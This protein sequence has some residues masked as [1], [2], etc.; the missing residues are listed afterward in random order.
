MVNSLMS[1]PDL[2]N[3]VSSYLEKPKFLIIELAGSLD[4]CNKLEEQ[5]NF[6]MN[7]NEMFEF[8]L[9]QFHHKQQALLNM[10]YSLLDMCSSYSLEGSRAD[11]IVNECRVLGKLLLEKLERLGVFQNGINNY[12]FAKSLSQKDTFMLWRPSSADIH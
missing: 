8:F 5:T 10:E 1:L 4:W 12:C 6:E 9:K 3:Q 7:M 11:I 2:S